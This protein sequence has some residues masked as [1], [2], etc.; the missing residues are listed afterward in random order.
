M[1]P[2]DGYDYPFKISKYQL[3]QEDIIDDRTK[4]GVEHFEG[5]H[6]HFGTE[7]FPDWE[8]VLSELINK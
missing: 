1:L 6:I 3:T 8:S 5:R 2:I 4:N 7:E